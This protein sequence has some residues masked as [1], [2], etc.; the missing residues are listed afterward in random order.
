MVC[1]RLSVALLLPVGLPIVGVFRPLW[2]FCF[3]GAC[4]CKPIARGHDIST[5][6]TALL[7]Y[8][9][10]T[11]GSFL[12]TYEMM[13]SLVLLTERDMGVKRD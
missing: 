4:L 9:K 7:P 1:G 10:S 13:L 12:K 3:S 2:C 11:L 5:P 6:N 8:P